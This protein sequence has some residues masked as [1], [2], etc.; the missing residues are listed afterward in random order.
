MPCWLDNNKTFSP[1]ALIATKIGLR[2]RLNLSNIVLNSDDLDAI[3]CALARVVESDDRL[4]GAV[5]NQH[6][7]DKYYNDER[8]K[9]HTKT[10]SFI[11]PKGYVLLKDLG[12]YEIIVETIDVQNNISVHISNL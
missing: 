3:I 11:S 5:L 1:L 8:F 9:T 4:E 2:P 6:L 7:T 10:R 12:K